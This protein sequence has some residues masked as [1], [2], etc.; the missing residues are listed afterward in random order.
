MKKN[1]KLKIFVKRI[2]IKMYLMKR[3]RI[4]RRKK[5][6]G[7]GIKRPYVSK[8]NRLMLGKGKKQKGGFIGPIV[9]AA[10]P[11]LLQAVSSIFG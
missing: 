10:A 4:K 3:R 1:I 11:A 2:K 8:R 6:T 9:A 5:I 7:K